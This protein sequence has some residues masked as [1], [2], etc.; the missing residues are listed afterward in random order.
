MR[1]DTMCVR[2][3]VPWEFVLFHFYFGFIFLFIFF[4]GI[5]YLLIPK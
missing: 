3:Y 4:G 2:T 1:L 5:D